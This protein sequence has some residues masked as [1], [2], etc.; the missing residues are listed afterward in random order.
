MPVTTVLR[1]GADKETS[2]DDGSTACNDN[3]NIGTKP[4]HLFDKNKNFTREAACYTKTP[5]GMATKQIPVSWFFLKQLSRPLAVLLCGLYSPF[6]QGRLKH[7]AP[8]KKC[9]LS[10]QKACIPD[11]SSLSSFCESSI[12]FNRG[13]LHLLA[14]S[15][16]AY[17][18]KH[19]G[20]Q[21]TKKRLGS[22]NQ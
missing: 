13:S 5:S 6:L 1:K 7:A 2:R 20:E 17:S 12:L 14:V 22:R 16:W 21:S 8:L 15:T 11:T 9:L 18:P 3:G 19:S 10:G 4:P